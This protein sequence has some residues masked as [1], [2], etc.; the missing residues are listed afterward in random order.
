MSTT[1]K[2]ERFR[3]EWKYL[4]SE[5]EKELIR[6]RLKPL[7]QLDAHA[8]DGS[9]MIRSL[10]FDDYWNSAYEEKEMGVLMRKK[11]RI[12]IYNCEAKNIKLER[13]KKFGNYIYK[14]DAP[15]TEEETRMIIRG[16]Y[17]FLL[18]SPHSL[19][20][21]F[22]VECVSHLMRPCVIVDYDREPWVMDVGTVRITFDADVRAAVGDFDIFDKSL[23][24]IPV[25][26]PGKVVMEVKFTELLPQVIRAVLPPT[27]AEFT[28]VSKY[29]LCYEKTR[30]LRGFEYWQN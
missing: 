28:A 22:Y 29:V 4:I 26:E 11:Y 17:D 14:E 7:I 1:K 8:R 24:A 10:Y 27:S 6:I 2:K 20:R 30:Y 13:K 19:C 21:E 23:P 3:N 25:L 12:R 9:Y 15:L 5:A 18:K 16:E